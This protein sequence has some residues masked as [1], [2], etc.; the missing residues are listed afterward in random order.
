M[1]LNLLPATVSRGAQS[2]TAW[3]A[4]V[5]IMLIG[6][7]AAIAAALTSQANLAQA[8]DAYETA[9]PLA[10]RAYATS[11]QADAIMGDAKVVDLV[12]NVALAES[13]I[14]HNDAYPNLYNSL[15]PYIPPFYRLTSLAATPIDDKTATVTMSG[16]LGS[17]QQYADLMLVLMR[18]PNAVSVSRSG[19]QST[20]A[21]VPQLTPVDQLGHPRKPGEQPVPD[22]PLQRLAYFQSQAQPA[23]YTGQGN[24]G[25]GT[26][27]TRGAMTGESLVTVQMVV[28]A[29]LQTPDPRGTLSTAAGGGGS[30]G[31]PTT[32][33]FPGGGPPSNI[34]AGPTGAPGSRNVTR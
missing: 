10:D 15:L 13:M 3:I 20:D 9:K 25:S 6:I 17:Y 12:K 7:G 28:N 32:T 22:D 26:D 24:F 23:A 19:F 16:T 4:S 11:A 8:K 5:I 14:S 31:A 30:T 27:N 34:P 18:N 2:R 21:I 29:N 33:G 1:K